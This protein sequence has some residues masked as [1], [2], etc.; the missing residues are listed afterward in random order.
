MKKAKQISERISYFDHGNKTTLIVSTKIDRWKEGLLLLWVLCWTASGAYFMYELATG[1]YDNQTR[2]A[3]VI[4]L[5]F[6]AFFEIRIGKALLWRKWGM[7]FISLDEDHFTL[8]Q[9][10]GSYGKAQR[11][12]WDDMSKMKAIEVSERSIFG[13]LESSFWFVGG[14]RIRFTVKKK[15]I[16]FGRQITHEEAKKVIDTI[17]KQRRAHKRKFAKEMEEIEAETPKQQGEVLDVHEEL[18]DD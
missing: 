4:M 16:K 3:F 14:E 11:F 13:N 17:V 10:I 7:E 12:F 1:D 2:V 15:T 18:K 5:A 6:W 8:K 9:S